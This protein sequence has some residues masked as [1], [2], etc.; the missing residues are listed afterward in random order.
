MRFALILAFAVSSVA[1]RPLL[2]VPGRGLVALPDGDGV[3]LSWRLL[4]DDP[5]NMAFHVDVIDE[6][7]SLIERLTGH[8]LRDVAWLKAPRPPEGARFALAAEGKDA[9]LGTAVV[10]PQPFI[11]IPLARRDG[12]A[13]VAV[14]DLNGDGVLDFVVKC[15]GGGIDPGRARPSP[16][17]YRIEAY[18]GRTRRHLWTHELGWNMNMGV[19]WTPMIAADLNGDGK[20]E[21]AFKSAHFADSYESSLAEKD[22]PAHGF[23]IS[24]E[25]YLTILEGATGREI[26]RT[27]WI[28]RGDP[29]AWGDNHGNRVNRNQMGVACLDGER[30]SLLVARGTYTRMIVH[31][32]DL[33][34]GKLVRRWIWDGDRETPRIRGQGAHGMHTVDLDGDGRDEIVLGSVVLK[35]DGTTLWSNGM[36]HPDIVY[37]ADIVPD[38][39]GLE[40][41]YGYEAAQRRNGIHVADGR[42]GRILWGH[43]RPTT[44]IHDQGMLADI[45][46]E[47]SAMEFYTAEKD[48]AKGSFLYAAATGKLLATPWLGTLSPRPLWWLDGPQKVWSPFGYR[49]SEIALIRGLDEEVARFPGTIVGIADVVGDWREEILVSVP[50][51]L[52]IVSTIIPSTTRH[53]WLM[54]DPLY[55]TNVAHQSMGYFYP[56]HLAKP[57]VFPNPWKESP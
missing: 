26:A 56:P 55:R 48:R 8:P 42:S 31:A 12:I 44:H 28:E 25:E 50:G 9:P 33:I 10:E 21:V 5:A 29:E 24:G 15:P 22:G 3:F 19:W 43:D 1:G 47:N 35:S 4:E 40:I 2:D 13:K 18:D 20:A 30:F 41:A 32:W 49:Q 6:Q 52:R 23:V 39:P 17:T 53:R 16:G 27:D 45:L 11:S 34:D 38:N 51:E 46:P 57:L 7:G 54:Q 14:A 37:V 36:G